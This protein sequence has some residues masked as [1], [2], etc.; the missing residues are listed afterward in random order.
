MAHLDMAD[1]YSGLCEALTRIKMASSHA[2]IWIS[3]REFIGRFG[4]SYISGVE[5]AKIAG[6][7]QGATF[8]SDAPV[9]LHAK[10]DQELDYAKHPYV[11]RGL[12]SSIPFTVSE[13]RHDP[14][15]AGQLWTELLDDVVKTGDGLILP[16]Y[17]DDEPL[18]GFIFAGQNP[19]TS[20]VARA[21][22]QVLAHAAFE[23]FVEL[24][25][26]TSHPAAS[27]LTVRE[28]QCLR[29]IATGHEDA[30]VGQMLGISP[31]TVR[32]HVDSAKTKLGVTS[33]VQAIAK[34]LREHIIAV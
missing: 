27:S 13:L 15:F 12:R 18:A 9:A 32:F 22:L 2:A 3:L 8:V 14:E 16:V 19:D 26:G 7:V 6:G 1:H 28:A 33:R 10:L 31:R 20:A 34:A 25:D 5:A 11:V 17:R 4:Y 23:K 29:L 21:T 24:R 30:Q